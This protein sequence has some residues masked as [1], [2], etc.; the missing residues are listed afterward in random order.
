MSKKRVSAFLLI[1][2]FTIFGTS[3]WAQSLDELLNLANDVT[4]LNYAKSL[5]SLS[6][7]TKTNMEGESGLTFSS[8]PTINGSATFDIEFSKSVELAAVLSNNG[9]EISLKFNPTEYDELSNEMFVDH[10][11]EKMKL[12]SKVISLFFDA[13]LRQRNVIQLSSES[14]SLQNQA[15]ITLEMSAYDYDLETLGSLLSIKLVKLDFPKLNIPKIPETYVPYSPANSKG[16]DSDLSFGIKADFSNTLNLGAFFNYS[17]NPK[18]QN[19]NS[20]Y[21]NKLL[22]AQKRRYFRDIHVLSK[23]VEAYDKHIAGLF[24]LYSNKYG[25]YL[26]GKATKKEVDEVSNQISLTG[27]ERDLYC[28]RLLKEWY[29]YTYFGD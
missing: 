8:T 19:D 9:L 20:N 14:S 18:V 28:I 3:L 22:E 2:L 17:W 1:V 7:I 25:E 4:N 29:L 27:Y 21:E 24:E 26:N 15:K 13:M 12:K 11:S 16:N 10:M 6:G 23:I 5:S